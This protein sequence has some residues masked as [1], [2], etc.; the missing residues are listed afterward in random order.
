MSETDSISK[1]NPSTL[2]QKGKEAVTFPEIESFVK[3]VETRPI[4]RL[5]TDLPALLALGDSKYHLVALAIKRRI[6]T[7]ES[8]RNEI[9]A[10]L[11]K[12]DGENADPI[13]RGRCRS[14]EAA[15]SG[16]DAQ[17]KST[18]FRS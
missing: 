1:P 14:F 7:N 15:K 17:S 2:V 8:E 5:L 16:A 13:I 11:R 9:L 10:Q 4:A 6:R 3:D 18:S 12:I